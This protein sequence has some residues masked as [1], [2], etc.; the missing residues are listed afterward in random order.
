MS[1]ENLLLLIS[2]MWTVAIAGGPAI[3]TLCTEKDCTAGAVAAAI[4]RISPE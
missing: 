2:V 4:P 3:H 1:C